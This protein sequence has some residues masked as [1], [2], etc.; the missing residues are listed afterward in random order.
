MYH[1]GKS[2]GNAYLT[3]LPLVSAQF[4]FQS[5]VVYRGGRLHPFNPWIRAFARRDMMNAFLWLWRVNTRTHNA[6]G[7]VLLLRFISHHRNWR[8]NHHLTGNSWLASISNINVATAAILKR[9]LCCE[10]L[11]RRIVFILCAS[12]DFTERKV[13]LVDLQAFCSCLRGYFYYP[14]TIWT[15]T[16]IL[17][18]NGLCNIEAFLWVWPA[19]QP[20][21]PAKSKA[22]KMHSP[23]HVPVSVFLCESRFALSGSNTT[24]IARLVEELSRHVHFVW[25]ETVFLDAVLMFE[26]CFI[27]GHTFMSH[28]KNDRA[29]CDPS[30]R[31]CNFK[32]AIPDSPFGLFCFAKAAFCHVCIHNSRFLGSGRNLAKVASS[33][34]LRLNEEPCLA[35]VTHLTCQLVREFV[36]E[37][38]GFVSRFLSANIVKPVFCRPA[39]N[40]S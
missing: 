13:L 40:I 33:S 5:F 9:R 12:T 32:Y 39:K 25:S 4:E 17:R 10:R 11:L 1:H 31:V 22:K 16:R 6:W 37:V 15:L 8:H 30:E 23:L 29:L 28:T 26:H 19:A 18:E 20:A 35:L 3:S 14:L 24:V 38:L 7:H 27:P 36:L 2:C 34:F 21:T